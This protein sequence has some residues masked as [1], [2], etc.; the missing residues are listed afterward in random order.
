MVKTTLT[1]LPWAQ[2]LAPHSDILI[3]EGPLT[4]VKADRENGYMEV[5]Q[6][7]DY[8][9]SQVISAFLLF[10]SSIQPTRK[11]SVLAQDTETWL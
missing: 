10:T 6:G 3:Y 9:A 1:I 4:W 5:V 11:C 8:Q 7:N 2:N